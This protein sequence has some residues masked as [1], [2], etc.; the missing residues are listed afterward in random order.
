MKIIFLASI[1]SFLAHI[2][3]TALSAAR[4]VTDGGE[5]VTGKIHDG[6]SK[7]DYYVDELEDATLVS[8]PANVART[9]AK[10]AKKNAKPKPVL[11]PSAYLTGGSCEEGF[12]R[13]ALHHP[14][15]N[16]DPLAGLF[17]CVPK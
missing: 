4:L 12:S 2:P 8:S 5:Y 1:L 14:S 9:Q 10:L 16:G 17:E 7:L 13:Q 6:F 11:K 15:Q 3:T